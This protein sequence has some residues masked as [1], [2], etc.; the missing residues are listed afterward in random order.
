PALR[1]ATV[2]KPRRVVAERAQLPERFHASPL[3]LTALALR[4]KRFSAIRCY[5]SYSAARKETGGVK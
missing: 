4:G 1:G 2:S 5:P 3:A